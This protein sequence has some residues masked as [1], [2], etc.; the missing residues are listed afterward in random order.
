MFKKILRY[1]FKKG[2]PKE[3]FTSPSFV[4][5]YQKKDLNS[6]VGVVTSKKVD[7]RAVVRNSI[8]RRFLNILKEVFL[9]KKSSYD[10]VFF[11][12]KVSLSK[13]KEDLS[14]EIKTA[15]SKLKK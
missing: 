2:L 7:K 11:L 4:L 13:S 9:E 8:K 3:I 15:L 12:R 1:S 6:R 10:L 14:Q 5:R